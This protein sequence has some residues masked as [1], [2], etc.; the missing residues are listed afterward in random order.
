MYY[1]NGNGN[2]CLIRVI[3]GNVKIEYWE[4]NSDIEL[5]D[6]GIKKM[7]IPYFNIEETSVDELKNKL[8]TYMLFS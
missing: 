4:H 1:N 8:K 5:W 7:N 3:F 6:G 2:L